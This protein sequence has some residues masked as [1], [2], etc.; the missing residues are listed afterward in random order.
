MRRWNVVI[1]VVL[2]AALLVGANT[3]AWA[4]LSDYDAQTAA[5]LEDNALEYGEL[6]NLIKEY[7]PQIKYAYDQMEFSGD[8]SAATIRE[9]RDVID[10]DDYKGQLKAAK[11]KKKQLE[12]MPDFEGKEEAVKGADAGIKLI[13]QMLNIPSSQTKTTDKQLTKAKKNLAQSVDQVLK[14]TQTLMISYDALR[15]QIKS[16]EMVEE[17]QDKSLTAAQVK[18]G[19]GLDTDVGVLQARSSL[20]STQSQLAHLK[21][22]ENG[23][24]GQLCLLTGWKVDAAPEIGS[25]P[26]A[27]PSLIASIDLAADIQKAI[28]NNKTL[29]AQRHSPSNKSTAGIDSRNKTIEESEERLTIELKRLYQVVLQ[30]EALYDADTTAYQK[31]L[32]SKGAAE[33]QLKLGSMNQIQYLGIQAQYYQAESSKKA[34]DTALLQA[35][36]DYDWAVKGY[37]EI[38]Q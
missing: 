29:I 6:E 13:G 27:D 8:D 12:Q 22:I 4:K 17:L 1:G 14:G 30:K 28:G 36:L 25:V 16:L 11:E 33:T 38:P 26:A 20:L 7:N 18:A 19:I 32:L 9:L 5:R 2:T 10:R 34:A 37:V 21:I 15:S 3:K 31:A 35:M 24:H 23:L